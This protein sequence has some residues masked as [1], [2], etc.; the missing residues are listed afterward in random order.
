MFHR[1]HFQNLSA[2]VGGTLSARAFLCAGLALLGGCVATGPTKVAEPLPPLVFPSPPEPAR[3]VFER[4]IMSSADVADV[5]ETTRWRQLVTGEGTRGTAISKPFDVSACQ[6]RIY[7][8]DSVRRTVMV[9]DVAGHRFF[10]IGTQDPGSLAKPLGI[11]TDEHCN[12]YVADATLKR[13]LI[14]NP[15]GQ[16]Q[17]AVGGPEMF[18]RLSHVAVDPAGTKVFAVDTGGVSSSNHHIRVFDAISGA[19]IRDI[20]ERGEGPGQFNLPRDIEVTRD[21]LVYVVDGGNFRV[22]VLQ[23]DG[24]HVRTF[25]TLGRQYGQFARPKGIASDPEGNIYVSDAAHGNFQIFNPQGQLLLFVGHRSTK[26]E[27]AAYMLPAG[28]DID[29]DGRVLMVD[30]FFRKVDIYRPAVL[31]ENAGRLAGGVNATATQP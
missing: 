7:V 1:N 31:A 5:D 19:H 14:Y 25:G 29:E 17:R 3:F 27:R 12:L 21:G 16:F 13:I 18:D 23:Q 20:G 8:S 30:Q 26:F 4:T 11:S 15:D 6:G 28:I 10:E 22:E 24:T 2:R 9:F